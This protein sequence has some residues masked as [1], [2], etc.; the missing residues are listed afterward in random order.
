[1][2]HQATPVWIALLP[3]AVVVA[4]FVLS[5]RYMKGKGYPAGGGSSVIV[6]C[7][8]GHLFTTIW[9]PLI[10]FKAV[11]L[12]SMR[13]QYCPVGQHWAFVDIVNPSDLTEEERQFAADHPDH[14]MP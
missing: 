13:Y 11:R 2:G 3:L 5:V 6:C 10:S 12:G 9:I 1:M 14:L 7:R 4:L 8:Q